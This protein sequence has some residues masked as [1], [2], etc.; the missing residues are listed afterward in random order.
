MSNVKVLVVDDSAAM[1]ALF[2]EILDEAKGVE[3]VGLARNVED[4]REQIAKLK[5]DVLTLDVEMPGMTGMEFLAELMQ[6]NPMPVVMLSSVTQDGTGTAQK[7]LE[8]GAYDC[9]PKPL[10]TSQEEF[11]ATV[12]KLGKIVIEAASAEVSGPA[13]SANG[14]GNGGTGFV[15]DGRLV[16]VAAS[17]DSIEIV[18]EIIAAYPGNCPP[19]VFLIDEDEDFVDRAIDRLHPS[20]ACRIENAVKDTVLVTG[21]VYIACDRTRHVLIEDDFAPMLKLVEKDP[22]A[23][24]RPSAD[25]FF[26]S[27]ARCGTPAIG[28]LLA[29]SHTDGVRGLNALAAAGS[30]TFLQD[31]DAVSPSARFDAA[32]AS[33]SQPELVSPKTI[34][35]WIIATTRKQA[36][37]A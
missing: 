10:H 25:M 7:A 14:S 27:I 22:V 12:A 33:A 28:G 17:A 30:P 20:V 34:P 11:T 6:T 36:A 37:A 26:A 4:A 3:V 5:P 9:F 19:T 23:G 16:A 18:R 15:P 2:S 24:H 21:S 1:R 29:A 32:M 35:D 31:A 8:L 13:T